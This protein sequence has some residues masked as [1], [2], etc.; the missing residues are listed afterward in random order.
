MVPLNSP[1][2]LALAPT[3]FGEFSNDLLVGNFGDG[4]INA[5]DPTTGKFLDFLKDDKGNPI[6]NMG[7]WGLIF[8]NGGTGGDPNTLYFTAGIAG[9]DNIEDHGLFGNISSVPL[10]GSLV[11][12]GSG[13]LALAAGRKKIF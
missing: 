9:P 12:L 4:R 10:P 7:L 5:F 1:W 6:E 11:L 3:D 8:G 2:G 13:L